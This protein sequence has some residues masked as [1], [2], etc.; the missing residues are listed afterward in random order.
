MFRRLVATPN[1]FTLTIIRLVLGGVFF[2][3]GAESAGLV[4]RP[5]L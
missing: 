4:G 1:D 3:H 2:A 5:W